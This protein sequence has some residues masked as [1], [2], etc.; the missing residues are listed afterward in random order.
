MHDYPQKLSGIGAWWLQIQPAKM[1]AWKI[2]WKILQIKSN[3]IKK[4]LDMTLKNI[5]INILYH[6]FFIYQDIVIME[7]SNILTCQGQKH[8]SIFRLISHRVHFI[9]SIATLKDYYT[10]TPITNESFYKTTPNCCKRWK[11][12][13]W[14]QQCT[15]SGGTVLD[16]S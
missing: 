4:T 14:P 1:W 16:S 7:N 8:I 9:I 11:D 5:G 15:Y 2:S 12:W 3:K 10:D 13:L 6:N